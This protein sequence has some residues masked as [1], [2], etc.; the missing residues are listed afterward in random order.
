MT[1]SANRSTS[2][3]TWELTITVRPCRPELLEE[4]DEMEPL[5]RI[6][7]VQRLVEDEHLRTDHQRGGD[8]RAL[9]HALAEAVDA[10]VGDVQQP[11][12]GQRGVR[13]LGSVHAVEVGDVAHELASR[14]PGRHRLVL[15]HE[16][17]PAVDTAVSAGVRGLRRGW[18]PG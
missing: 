15:R 3:S 11:D 5:H 10:P 1:R 14:E 17:H 16:R 4:V 12:G 18:C 9:A 6:S 13:R 8:L 7:T 2:L